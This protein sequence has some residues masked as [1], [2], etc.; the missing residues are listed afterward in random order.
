MITISPAII[1][2]IVGLISIL[3]SVFAIFFYFQKPQIALEK[4]VQSLE[5]EN[6]NLSRDFEV[7]KAAHLE[8]NGSMQKEMKELTT[9]VN[10]LGKTVVRLST[11]I[12]ERIPKGSPNLTPPGV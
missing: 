6:R 9:A 2:M 4:R 8:N 1:G 3:G 10:D 5:E 11:I 12:D 7:M